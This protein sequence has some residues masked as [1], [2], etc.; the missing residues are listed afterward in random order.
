MSFQPLAGISW[1][2]VAS[3]PRP[4]SR[5]ALLGSGAT[6]VDGPSFCCRFL[7]GTARPG[8]RSERVEP[9]PVT[10]L[11]RARPRTAPRAGKREEVGRAGMLGRLGIEIIGQRLRPA[12]VQRCAEVRKLRGRTN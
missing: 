5:P 3:R 12:Q 10:S 2:D 1:G 9:R 7:C 8:T 6:F 11:T 4:C